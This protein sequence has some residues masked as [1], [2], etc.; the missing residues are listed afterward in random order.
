MPASILVVLLILVVIGR[1]VQRG[2]RQGA[3]H[4]LA[5]KERIRPLAITLLDPVISLVIVGPI[6][7]RLITLSSAHTVAAIA[8]G[9]V[10]LAIGYWRAKVMFV[11]AVKAERLV[12]L[13]RHG[14]EYV[15]L[16]VLIVARTSE[17]AVSKSPASGASLLF[18]FLVALGVVESLARTA[19]IVERYRAEA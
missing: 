11:R 18:A 14:L 5:P 4:S 3:Q 9:I 17:N 13:R 1:L 16:L 6:F 19:F 10:G 12:V 7:L 8:G 2:R 15:L